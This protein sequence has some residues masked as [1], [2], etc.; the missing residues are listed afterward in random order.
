[1]EV[2]LPAGM[3]FFEPAVVTRRR[4]SDSSRSPWKRLRSDRE[5]AYAKISQELKRSTD[6]AER[7]TGD[8]IGRQLLRIRRT[9]D[10]QDA[11]SSDAI[12]NFELEG[13]FSVNFSKE[14]GGS[15]SEELYRVSDWGP[16][17]LAVSQAASGRAWR[18][19]AVPE[20]FGYS[21]PQFL[22]ELSERECGISL[23]SIR[24]FGFALF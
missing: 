11:I 15:D 16:G 7:R 13:Y 9:T 12:N 3:N 22:S 24:N 21:R 18:A 17:R 14:F 4:D 8:F 23:L 2:R 10:L 6:S 19:R 1:M 20:G 5:P